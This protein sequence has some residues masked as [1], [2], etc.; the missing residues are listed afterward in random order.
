[1]ITDHLYTHARTRPAQPFLLYEDLVLSYGHV[2][3]C[4]SAFAAALHDRGVRAGERVGLLCGNRPEFLV[5][6]FAIIELGAIAVPM[7]TGLVGGG[8]RHILAQSEARLLLAETALLE[9]RRTDLAQIDLPLGVLQIDETL[10]LAGSAGPD[11]RWRTEAVAADLDPACIL[12]TS[13]TTGLPKGVVLPHRAYDAAGEDMLRSLDLKVSDRVLVFLPLF[14]ANPQMYAVSA[15]LVVGATLVLRPRFSASRFFDDAIRY[16]AT[17]FTFVGTVLS[18]LEKQHPGTRHDHGL[19][20]CVGGGA[21]ARVWSEVERRFGIHVNELYGMTETGGWVSMNTAAA[22]R[23]GSVGLPRVGVELTVRDE[24]GAPVAAMVKGEITARSV[25]PGV[26]FT[27]YWNNPQATMD[28]LRG[29]WLY[30]GD[31]GY[32]DADGYLYFDGRVKELIRRGGEMIAPTEVEQQL[33]KHAAVADCAVVGVPD[34]IMG[35]EVKAYIVASVEVA[36]VELREF[37]RNRVPDYMIPRFFAFVA[38]IPKTETQKIRRQDLA[39]LSVETV[40]TRVAPVRDAG[41]RKGMGGAPPHPSDA[42]G[43]SAD[44]AATV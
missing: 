31:R 20:W 9:A 7:N 41:G 21:P 40:D 44:P 26:F 2:A 22:T 36:P 13:G 11:E 10:L 14:H 1:M 32:L 6:W 15:V 39:G 25:R 8:L 42:L 30:T 19:R 43:S 33:L 16:A 38:A 4:V 3:G 29:G 27:E 17:G 28:T 34:E 37:L 23:R 12:Y 35:E 5:C 18:I 24:R